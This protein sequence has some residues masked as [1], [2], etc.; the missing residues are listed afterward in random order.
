MSLATATAP[1]AL[2]GARATLRG[3]RLAHTGGSDKVIQKAPAVKPRRRGTVTTASAVGT[4]LTT[5]LLRQEMEH[6]IDGELAVV[7]SSVSIACKRVR[8]RYRVINWP[9]FHKSLT[10][11]QILSRNTRP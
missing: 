1:V 8:A 5:W 3:R 10:T 6:K 2:G 7:L 11:S 4:N 9:P